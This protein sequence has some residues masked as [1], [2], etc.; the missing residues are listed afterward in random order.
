MIELIFGFGIA[1]VLMVAEYLLC[2]KLKSPL[3]GSRP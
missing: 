1:T 3:W 2:T